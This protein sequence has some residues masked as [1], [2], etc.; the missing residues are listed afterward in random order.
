MRKE[1]TL[2]LYWSVSE[3]AG[4]LGVNTSL[5]RYYEKEFDLQPRRTGTGKGHRRYTRKEIDRL[6]HIQ[7]LVKEMGFTLNGARKQLMA[8]PNPVTSI[9]P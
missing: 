9:H 8:T 4:E 3:V 5:I 1:K 2:K 7:H 6:K